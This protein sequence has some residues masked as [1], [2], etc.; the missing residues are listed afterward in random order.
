MGGYVELVDG[1]KF[2]QNEHQM[3]CTRRFLWDPSSE[4]STTTLPNIGDPLDIGDG[5]IY[6]S[7]VVRSRNK[8]YIG[9]DQ[10]KWIY[11]FEYSNEPVDIIGAFGSNGGGSLGGNYSTPISQDFSAESIILNSPYVPDSSVPTNIWRWK[12]D[13]DSGYR[14]AIPQNFPIPVIVPMAHKKFIKIFDEPSYKTFII[15]S[16]STIGKINATSDTPSS[17]GSGGD[18][19][20]FS[21]YPGCWLYLGYSAEIYFNHKDAKCYRCELSFS[22]RNPPAVNGGALEN[23]YGWD[24]ILRSNNTWDI[25]RGQLIG[26]DPVQYNY[27]Y[28]AC[29]NTSFSNLGI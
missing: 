29:G 25:P 2:I 23:A 14:L 11:T 5:N 20:S 27:I 17:G 1:W 21:N 13:V 8:R 3:T 4:G 18:L 12:S 10:T 19:N 16:L 22:F 15:Q 24:K 6:Y 26:S 28:A 9:E 7:C